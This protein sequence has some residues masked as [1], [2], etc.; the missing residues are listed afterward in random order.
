MD[1][2]DENRVDELMQQVY[3]DAFEDAY[4]SF[5]MRKQ[6]DPLFTR[7][8]LQG[9]LSSLYV[10]QGNNWD[11]RGQTRET[12]HCALIAAAELVFTQW[13]HLEQEDVVSPDASSQ[14][15]HRC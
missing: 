4:A 15:P 1:M 3:D 5:V 12:A 13:D 6:R 7:N 10:Q 2:D 14:S 9:L 8:F 11:G